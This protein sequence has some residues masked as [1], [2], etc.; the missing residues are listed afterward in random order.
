MDLYLDLGKYGKYKIM[1]GVKMTRRE[2]L[3]EYLN[4]IYCPVDK[5]A[6]LAQLWAIVAENDYRA[7]EETDKNKK[8]LDCLIIETKG[9]GSRE[10]FQDYLITRV[11]IGEVGSATAS[12]AIYK[13]INLVTPLKVARDNI[14]INIPE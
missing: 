4:K 2:E 14:K 8:F 9:K 7:I 10:S 6:K 12:I 1:E 5:T 3:R 13:D 11:D